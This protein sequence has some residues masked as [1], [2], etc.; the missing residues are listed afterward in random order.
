MNAMKRSTL[1]FQDQ[2]L[3]SVSSPS[4]VVSLYSLH[5]SLREVYGVELD[6][7]R[8]SNVL[9]TSLQIAAVSNM[10]QK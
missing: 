7:P 1:P 8:I 3:L 5:V 6:H 10:G 4:M 2:G 9:W